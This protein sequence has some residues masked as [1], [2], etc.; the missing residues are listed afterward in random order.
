MVGTEHLK[1]PIM[2]KQRGKVGRK[3]A[4]HSSPS[5]TFDDEDIVMADQTSKNASE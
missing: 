3:T 4:S 1:F 2:K 5:E